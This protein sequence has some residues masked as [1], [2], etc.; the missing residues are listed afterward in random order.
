VGAQR[1]LSNT[2]I[3]RCLAAPCCGAPHTILRRCNDDRISIMDEKHHRRS[4]R[5]QGYNYTQAGVYFVTLVARKRECLFGKIT[6]G[7]MCPNEIG[8]IVQSEWERLSRR[9]IWTEL[10]EYIL[11]P[12]H[13]HGII[14][15]LDNGRGAASS[16]I[17]P[18]PDRP[19]AP[20]P[21]WTVAGGAAS[22]SINPIPKWPAAPR[23][24]I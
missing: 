9:F 16:S 22:S 8:K 15:F 10:D 1:F 23:P 24:N 6:D 14:V 2:R 20:Q 18:F 12:N 11:M 5:L 17:N 3:L 13:I 21:N 4:I 19:A 7:E